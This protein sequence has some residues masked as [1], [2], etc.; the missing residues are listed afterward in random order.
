MAKMMM[1][2]IVSIISFVF[3]LPKCHFSSSQVCGEWS[4]ENVLF[5]YSPPTSSISASFSPVTNDQH[6]LYLLH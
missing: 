5:K 3:I 6:Q 4:E 2:L 1:V